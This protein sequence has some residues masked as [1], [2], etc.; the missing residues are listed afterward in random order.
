M[1]GISEIITIIADAK[2]MDDY[3]LRDCMH[4]NCEFPVVSTASSFARAPIEANGNNQM[5]IC[6]DMRVQYRMRRGK[7]AKHKSRMCHF[8]V[9]LV[10]YMHVRNELMKLSF[11][12]LPQDN[13]KVQAEFN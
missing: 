9:R 2:L 8:L 12:Y 3:C 1:E 10:G 5:I 6:V 4:L 13:I 11:Q 7:C